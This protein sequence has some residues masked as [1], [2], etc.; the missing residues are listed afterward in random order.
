MVVKSKKEK[1]VSAPFSKVAY[2]TY[3]AGKK[4]DR[5]V[6]KYEYESRSARGHASNPIH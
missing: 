2:D 4:V 5:L 3:Y 1:E 6:Q